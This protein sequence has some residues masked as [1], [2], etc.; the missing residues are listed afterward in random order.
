VAAPFPIIVVLLALLNSLL[1]LATLVLL[2]LVCVAVV[3]VSA[4][5]TNNN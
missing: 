2:P 1:L 3:W 5:R 4:L